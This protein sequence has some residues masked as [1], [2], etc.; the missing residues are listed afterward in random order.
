M[1]EII[2]TLEKQ[3]Q[4]FKQRKLLASPLAGLFAWLAVGISGLFFSDTISVWVLFIATGS[5]VYLAMAISKLTGEDFLDKSRPKNTFDKLFFLTVAQSILVYA[6]AIP[7]FFTRL[8]F[9]SVNCWNFDR[10]DVASRDMD[11]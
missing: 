10:I 8:Y 7:F 1:K 2:E 11:Y 4:E 3:K 5:I 9:T 6:I